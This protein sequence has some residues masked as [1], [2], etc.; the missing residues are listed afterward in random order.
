MRRAVIA[1]AWL[2]GA[3][4]PLLL[5]T[6][7]IFGCCVLPFHG[8]IHK[9]MPLCSLAINVIH[10][11][12]AAGANRQQAPARQRQEPVKRLVTEVPRA[13]HLHAAFAAARRIEATNASTYRS[14]ITLGA[15]RCDRD[16]GLQLFVA[17]LLI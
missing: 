1:A 3:T 12:H 11:E 16:V 8:V 15:V 17:T 4:V 5:A 13:F 7:M 9:V 2:V 10:G 14:F 6:V